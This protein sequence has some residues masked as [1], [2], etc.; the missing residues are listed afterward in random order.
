MLK[1][2][3][4]SYRQFCKPLIGDLKILA[5]EGISV[6]FNGCTIQ[7]FGGLATVYKIQEDTRSFI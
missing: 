3:R 1:N 5:T 4:C 6:D 7:I 2:E